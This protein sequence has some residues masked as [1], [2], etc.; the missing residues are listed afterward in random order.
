VAQDA[1]MR[2]LL[3]P[4]P[5]AALFVADRSAM[6]LLQPGLMSLLRVLVSLPV[7]HHGGASSEAKTLVAR[8]IAA[9]MGTSF[10]DAMARCTAFVAGHRFLATER[11]RCA[12]L[13]FW[14]SGSLLPLFAARP[15]P[16][17]PLHLAVSTSSAAASALLLRAGA[18][19]LATAA[20]GLPSPLAAAA[21]E[22]RELCQLAELTAY[23]NG[24]SC[25]VAVELEFFRAMCS[26]LAVFMLL[27][28]AAERR[29]G[30]AAVAAAL[31]ALPEVPQ[32]PCLPL[33]FSY[34]AAM[35]RY[36]R[37]AALMLKTTARVNSA[38]AAVREAEAYI[39]H[40]DAAAAARRRS[41]RWTCSAAAALLLADARGLWSA[42][43]FGLAS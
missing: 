24:P 39:E 29:H 27:R 8:R 22:V 10:G 33:G 7:A 40:G 20:P 28:R 30:A 4:A 9:L 21:A 41:I 37:R 6:I 1:A 25:D 31:P 36:D 14:V 3:T 43:R 17:M 35:M 18:D 12:P 38:D 26:S 34:L 11:A 13:G 2:S 16:V 19:P 15:Q 5:R 32:P 42:W 23:P